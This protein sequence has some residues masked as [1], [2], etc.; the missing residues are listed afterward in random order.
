MDEYFC[1]IVEDKDLAARRN[2]TKWCN[3][4]IVR[5]V[6][7]VTWEAPSWIFKRTKGGGGGIE[8]AGCLQ[9]M[10]GAPSWRSRGTSIVQSINNLGETKS[11]NALTTS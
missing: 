11:A 6:V 9:Q 4:L 1:D 3:V 2:C 7:Y 8:L 10:K 5:P